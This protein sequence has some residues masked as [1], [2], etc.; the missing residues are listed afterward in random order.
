MGRKRN[1][2]LS[3]KKRRSTI[4][5]AENGIRRKKIRY[6]AKVQSLFK[7]FCKAA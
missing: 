7:I 6:V 5:L 1:N 3:E 2:G 4:E